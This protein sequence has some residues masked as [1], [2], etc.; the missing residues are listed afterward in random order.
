M[1]K[2]GTVLYD[3]RATWAALRALGGNTGLAKYAFLHIASHA[4]YDAVSGR[5]SGL[6]LHDRDVWL[7]EVWELAPLPPLFSLSAC[8]GMQSYLYEGDE[9]IG[10]ATTCL[11]AGAQHVVGSLWPVRDA[12]AASVMSAFYRYFFEGSA[13]PRAL[14][15][16][17]R[18]A[19]MGD[20][21]WRCWAP[22]ICVGALERG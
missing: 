5:A 22:F 13:P 20:S 17:Q 7:D 3:E 12:G 16:A 9:P 21:A 1:D 6:A 14:A 8:S 19:A 18:Q 15:M 2:R 10:L 11:Q 4:F